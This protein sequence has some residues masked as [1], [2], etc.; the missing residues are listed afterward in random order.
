MVRLW[1]EGGPRGCFT[2]LEQTWAHRWQSRLFRK[3]Q[4]SRFQTGLAPQVDVPL[5]TG[6]CFRC[7]YFNCVSKYFP[8]TFETLEARAA[9][10][11]G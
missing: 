8:Q 6:L 1:P 10:K 2:V 4:T 11:M 3:E 9:R 5:E 7:S